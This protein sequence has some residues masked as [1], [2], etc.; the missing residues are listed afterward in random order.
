MRKA[1][2]EKGLIEKQKR[3]RGCNGHLCGCSC[4]PTISPS[5]GN[6]TPPGYCVCMCLCVCMRLCGCVQVG[7]CPSMEGS[8]MGLSA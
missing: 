5:S 2:K 7:S 6:S 3:G 8:L 4:P 1:R